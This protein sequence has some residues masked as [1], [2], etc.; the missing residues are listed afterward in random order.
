MGGAGVARRHA[1]PVDAQRLAPPEGSTY[2]VISAA[3]RTGNFDAVNGTNVGGGRS[4]NVTYA[5]GGVSLVSQVS[6]TTGPAVVSSTP[7]PLTNQPVSSSAP[8]L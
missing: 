6:D 2:A 7:L 5:P 4:F 8:Q 1:E 3:S